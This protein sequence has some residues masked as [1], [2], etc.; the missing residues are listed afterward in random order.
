MEFNDETKAQIVHI[1][2]DTI[3]KYCAK[4]FDEG[5]VLPK[6]VIKIQKIFDIINDREKKEEKLKEIKGIIL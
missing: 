2:L 4:I 6:D 1:Q 5:V 3:V